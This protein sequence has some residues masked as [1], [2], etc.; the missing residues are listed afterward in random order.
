MMIVQ[1]DIEAVI[2]AGGKARRMDGCD[3]GLQTYRGIPLFMCVA[4]RLSSQIKSITINANRNIEEY[5][6]SGFPVFFDQKSGFLGPLSGILSGL[7]QAQSEYVLF[8]PCDSPFLPL[9]LVTRLYHQ[10]E[11]QQ[12]KIAYVTDG[13]REHPTFVLIH[14]SLVQALDD[15]LERGERRLLMFMKE[16]G[17]INVDFS[18]QKSAFININTLDELREIEQLDERLG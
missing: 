3:K 12:T 9:D 4:E 11:Q 7:L 10:L 16:N 13:E 6:K 14:R 1:P 17:G 8:V 2:L 5:K 18:D 15:Y